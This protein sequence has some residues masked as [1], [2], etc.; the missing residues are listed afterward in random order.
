MVCDSFQGGSAQTNVISRNYYDSVQYP[1][2][3][4]PVIMV[5][6]ATDRHK[7]SLLSATTPA[8]STVR[9]IPRFRFSALTLQ[10]LLIAILFA[11]LF[12]MAVRVPLDTDTW[13]HLRS[14]D[15]ILSTHTIPPVDPFSL[16]R[17]GQPWID[18]SWLAQI[19]MLGFY[20]LL[21]GNIGLAL[22][23]AILATAGMACVFAAS[24]GNVYLRAFVAVLA[25][26]TAAVFWSARPQ[27]MSFFLSALVLYIL[28]LYK[29]R[30]IDRLWLLPPLFILW[31]N[32]H[33]GFAIG[34]IFMGGTIAGEVIGR[35]L[36]PVD[37]NVLTWPML[38]KLI[39]IAVICAAV[40]V[41]NPYTVQMWTY[42]FKTAGIGALEQFIQE[43]ASPDFHGR[44]TWPFLALLFGTFAAAG[45][46]RRGWDWSDLILVCGTAFMALIWQRNFAVFAVAAA[47]VLARHLNTI[48]E[49]A[50]LHIAKSPPP[51]GMAIVLNWTLLALVIVGV[52]FKCLIALN[53]PTVTQAQA[54]S[55]P[56]KAAAYLNAHQPPGNLFNTYNWGGYL[57]FAAPSYPVF[58]DGRTDLYG[59]DL[60]N[61]WRSAILGDGWH[62]LFT[63]WGIKL[64]VIEHD[65]PLAAILRREP[66][67]QES[68]SDALASIFEAQ[69]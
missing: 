62:D 36:K 8:N 18:Q 20:R 64:V 66:G 46:S 40:L 45:F 43:W 6:I 65:S 34:F 67:W 5:I 21:G 68:Y 56:V 52:L 12:A 51:R 33:S 1:A 57:L 7:D 69:P 27:M 61:T 44:E 11:L 15:F 9:T 19:V 2:A 58:V 59:S 14:A 13:W 38:R 63:K 50:G 54:D 24:E 22:Y 31:V 10:R 37:P 39:L 16:T 23:T 32:L 30:K 60:L 35:V 3:H 25:A 29:W 42:P 53:T 55:L 28:F 41:I 4:F 17:G 48:L 49:N 47:P 26:T